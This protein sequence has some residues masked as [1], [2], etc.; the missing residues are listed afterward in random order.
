[1]TAKMM[2]LVVGAT[3]VAAAAN[4]EA[5]SLRPGAEGVRALVVEADRP[6]TEI[7]PTMYG[8]F[9]EDINFGADAGLCAEL[10]ANRSFEYPQRLMC[11]DSFGNVTVRDDKPAFP[12]NP[13]Y[14]SLE[15]SGH[16]NKLTGLYNRGFFGMGFKKGANYD[17]SVYARLHL[18][19]GRKAKFRVEMISGG[20]AVLAGADVEVTDNKWRRHA[21]R[22]TSS[23]TDPKGMLRIILDKNSEGVD[24]DHVS[25]F[26]ADNWHGLRPDLIR[27]LEDLK[28][29]VFRF[30]GG[31]IV[32]GD[33]LATRYRWK[34]T[35]GPAENRPLNES[36]WKNPVERLFPHYFQSNGLGYYEYFLLAERLGAEPLPVV[37]VGLA[38][39]FR[40]R[41]DDPNAHAAVTNLQE[42]VDE[43]L[44]LIEF[45]TGPVTSKW[46]AV[47][48]ELGHPA[49]F[50]MKQIGIGNEQW[51]RLYVDRA[52]VF[53]E[54]IRAKHPE[55][56]ICG[57]AGPGAGGEEFDFLWKEMRA[58]GADVV[59]EHYYRDAKWFKENV[60][61]YD[62]Y[63][64][65]GP[66]V[67]VGEYA[68]MW[69][70]KDANSWTPKGAN[71]WASAL[72]EAAFMTGFERNADVVREATYAPL[73]AHVDGWQCHHN[74]I[75]FDTLSVLRTPNYYVQQLYAQN[76]GTYVL[77]LT[78]DGK[79]VTGEG[80]LYATACYDKETDA[81]I[82]K[83]ANVSTNAQQVALAFKGVSA[84]KPGTLTT[85][86]ADDPNAHNTFAAPDVVVPT[87]AEV[88][89]TGAVQNLTLPPSSFS[90]LRL[91]K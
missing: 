26:P 75:W 55:I 59:D 29:G 2:K 31:C 44:D 84:L 79:A 27:A 56:G 63:D 28:P 50:A 52:K 5:E 19:N 41:D 9:F 91:G 82:V 39:Q 14:V 6:G 23:A 74:L 20:N 12:R 67:F 89:P 3:V 45:A 34:D 86:Q 72:A 60:T 65:S 4:V 83:V 54:A 47:R 40:N 37:G 68:C 90:V 38:C 46:G 81:C 32:E 58:L 22:L 70:T 62:G 7:Q 87:T 85:L 73:F 25:L 61:R 11:W 64:R 48:A 76:A 53:F 77:P 10:V 16:G 80:G 57:S 88:R 36:L 21:V 69:A 43:A 30:P 13:H 35:I 71:S 1:M 78:E 18:L 66:K 17:F 33:D 49:P 15:P 24:L 8:I 51:G 42:Y